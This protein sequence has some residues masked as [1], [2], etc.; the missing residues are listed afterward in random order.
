LLLANISIVK[1]PPAFANGWISPAICPTVGEL[2]GNATRSR[3]K[4]LFD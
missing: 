2:L 3:R 1:E 4:R